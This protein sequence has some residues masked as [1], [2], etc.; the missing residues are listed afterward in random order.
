MKKV[1]IQSLGTLLCVLF[2]S[3]CGGGSVGTKAGKDLCN[4]IEEVEKKHGKSNNDMSAGFEALGCIM[5]IAEKY[6]D[7]LGDDQNF[8]NSKDQK[9][10]EAALK[11]CSPEFAEQMKDN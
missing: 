9:D 10:F 7:H 11:K 3:S 5:L 6:K 4:C 8:K 1:V 2:L